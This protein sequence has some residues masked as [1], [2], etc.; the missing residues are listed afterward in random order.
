MSESI[1][2]NEMSGSPQ[3][4]DIPE[5]QPKYQPHNNTITTEPKATDEKD[6]F[7]L[8]LEWPSGTV[9]PENLNRQ[10]TYASASSSTSSSSS[11]SDFSGHSGYQREHNECTEFCIELFTCFGVVDCC[12]KNGEGCVTSVATWLGNLVFSCCKC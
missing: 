6:P 11:G 12:P 10:K 5:Q 4:Q 1:S 3:P 9:N 7:K 8:Q 2:L